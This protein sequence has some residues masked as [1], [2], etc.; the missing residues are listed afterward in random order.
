[1]QYPNEWMKKFKLDTNELK[2]FFIIVIIT[3]TIVQYF[4]CYLVHVHVLMILVINYGFTCF[5]AKYYFRNDEIQL[6]NQSSSTA[7]PT[8]TPPTSKQKLS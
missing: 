4:L 7:P 6:W 3:F 1:M 5:N 8:R 2:Y